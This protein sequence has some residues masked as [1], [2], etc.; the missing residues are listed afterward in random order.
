MSAKRVEKQDADSPRSGRMFARNASAYGM[1]AKA[2]AER[3]ALALTV[4]RRARNVYEMGVKGQT[5]SNRL[6][7]LHHG[8]SLRVKDKILSCRRLPLPHG[9]SLLVQDPTLSYRR[10]PLQ[11]GML[12]RHLH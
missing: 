3:R 9:R 5:P 7:P 11:H 1:K 6:L 4:K 10:L 2:A 12:I 8:R